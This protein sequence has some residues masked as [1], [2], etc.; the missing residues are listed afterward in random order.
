MFVLIIEDKQDIDSKLVKYLETKGHSVDVVGAELLSKYL[1]LVG[2]YDA[3]VLDVSKLEDSNVLCRKL[4]EKGCNL[5]P[6]MMV[7]PCGSVDDEIAAIVAGADDFLVKPLALS[8]I[9]ARLR[10]LFRLN[11]GKKMNRRR[12]LLSI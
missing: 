11:L 12:D 9:E 10:V 6:I 7:S 5:T 2:Q 1:A 8:E 3:I 4:R